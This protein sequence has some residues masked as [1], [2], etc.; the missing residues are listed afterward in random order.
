MGTGSQAMTSCGELRFQRAIRG[1]PMQGWLT[2]A[3]SE[4]DDDTMP[5]NGQKMMLRA[6]GKSPSIGRQ[7]SMAAAGEQLVRLRCLP[8]LLLDLITSAALS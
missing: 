7:R 5:R 3:G 6:Q 8:Y 1:P 2:L 4:E